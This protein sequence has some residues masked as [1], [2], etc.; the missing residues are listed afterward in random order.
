MTHT[1]TSTITIFRVWKDSGQ[2]I[3]LFPGLN[4]DTGDANYGMCMSYEHVGQHGEADYDGVVRASRPA[5][6]HEIEDLEFELRSL[7]YVLDIRQRKPLDL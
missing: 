3:A 2:V 1:E 4:Y 5:Q 6:D 7:G